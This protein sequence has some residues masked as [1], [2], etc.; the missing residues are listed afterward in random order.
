MQMDASI[1]LFGI[2]NIPKKRFDKFGK[3]VTDENDIA[4][5]R[6]VIQPKFETPMMNFS[7]TGVNPI[8]A[9]NNT[10]T[11]PTFGSASVPRG[12]WHQ[13]GVMPENSEKG[14]FLEI[15]DIPETWLANHYQVIGTSSVYNNFNGVDAVNTFRKYKSFSDLM[16]F[17]NE[18]SRVRLGEV[19]EKR[20][21]REAVVAVPYISAA[22]KQF[23]SIPKYRFDAA[24]EVATDSAIGNSLDAAGSSIRNQINKMKQFVLPPQFDFINNT[25]IDPIVMYIFDFKYELDKNDLSYIWQNTAPRNSR[26]VDLAQDAVAHEL[27]NTELLT[28]QNLFDNDQLRWMV[29]KVKQRSQAKYDDVVTKQVSQPIKLI[30]AAPIGSTNAPEISGIQVEGTENYNIS[31]NWPYDYVSIIET[32]KIDT[33]ILFKDRDPV[34]VDVSNRSA[35]QATPAPG[36][37]EG[38]VVTG[39]TELIKTPS[40]N[41]A[42]TA[43]VVNQTLDKE[44]RKARYAN[45]TAKK[46]SAN[47][48]KAKDAG[49][50]PDFDLDKTR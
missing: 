34:E 42:S 6:W 37:V 22:T 40:P 43:G 12:M 13:F 14:I 33:G 1:N 29:F 47:T 36:V 50:G 30:N 9:E 3:L 16:G 24:L 10:L 28:E 8:S 31:Y 49:P 32:V 35:A 7:D 2:E 46:G 41:P 21:I 27:V 18:N 5:Q 4:A 20:V 23:I 44:L 38:K 39:K 17:T 26:R 19:S 25:T 15:G 48:V 45:P 11:L